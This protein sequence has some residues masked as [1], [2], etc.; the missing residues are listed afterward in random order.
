MIF[1]PA[2][3]IAMIRNLLGRSLHLENV[4]LTSSSCFQSQRLHKTVKPR[5]ADALFYTRFATK[6]TK[7]KAIQCY[8]SIQLLKRA[9][10]ES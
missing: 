9:S 7:L 4:A 6:N 3:L 2:L 1:H 5:T 8:S 10:S